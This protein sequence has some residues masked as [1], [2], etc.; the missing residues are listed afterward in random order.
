MS[1]RAGRPTQHWISIRWKPPGKHCGLTLPRGSAPVFIY[2]Q[3]TD[4]DTCQHPR[5]PP[6][7]KTQSHWKTQAWCQDEL[8]DRTFK[9]KIHPGH[10]QTPTMCCCVVLACANCSTTL[11]VISTRV[12]EHCVLMAG[13]R[14]ANY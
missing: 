8:V 6:H 2:W 12:N 13:D 9:K 14:A 4:K 11:I 7:T 5:S 10:A 1:P 3:R